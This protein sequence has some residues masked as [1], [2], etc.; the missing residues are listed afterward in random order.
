MEMG[1]TGPGVLDLGIVWKPVP[2]GGGRRSDRRPSK[3]EAS[4]QSQHGVRAGVLVEYVEGGTGPLRWVW[5]V[6]EHLGRE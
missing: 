6:G 3:E 1:K 2:R 4:C 5:E